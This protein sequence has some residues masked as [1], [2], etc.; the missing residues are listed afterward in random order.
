MLFEILY[1][2][3]KI[4]KELITLCI[5]YSKVHFLSIMVKQEKYKG[6]CFNYMGSVLR[7]GEVLWSRSGCSPVQ[8][9]CFEVR[10]SVMGLNGCVF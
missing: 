5:K 1:S 2:I 6:E 10:G 4:R 3:F 9:E 8:G 7:L